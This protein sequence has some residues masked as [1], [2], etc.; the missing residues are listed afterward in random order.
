MAAVNG[1]V[2]ITLGSE[3]P[4]TLQLLEDDGVV[5]ID[6]TGITVLTLYMRDT[7]DGSLKEITGAKLTVLDAANGKIKLSQVSADFPAAASYRYKIKFMDLATKQHFVPDGSK[8][9]F[10]TI[11]DVT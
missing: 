7:D 9:Y 3:D 1:D 4:V 2:E 10:F 8:W 5:P 11:Y 6:L